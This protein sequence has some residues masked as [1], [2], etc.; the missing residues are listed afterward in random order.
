MQNA[1][2]FKYCPQIWNEICPVFLLDSIMFPTSPTAATIICI[3]S[4]TEE[5]EK[6]TFTVFELLCYVRARNQ[7][8]TRENAENIVFIQKEFG[9]Q[10]IRDSK[11][12][13]SRQKNGQKAGR[14]ENQKSE[15]QRYPGA[16]RNHNLNK[17]KVIHEKS[18]WQTNPRGDESWK[19]K[20]RVLFTESQSSGV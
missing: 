10:V 17:S 8:Q 7:M 20:Q 16:G 5:S 4:K 19:S 14:S 11:D 3:Q 15:W 9:S 18:E 2:F 6:K 1:H 13:I 12:T